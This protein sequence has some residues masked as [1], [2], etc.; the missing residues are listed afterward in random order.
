MKG[1]HGLCS[2]DDT[3]FLTGEGCLRCDVTDGKR[4]AAIANNYV[5][6]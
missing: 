6:R 1:K 5:G 2:S 4:V 3:P